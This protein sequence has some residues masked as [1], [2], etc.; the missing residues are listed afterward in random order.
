MATATDTRNNVQ[1]AADEATRATFRAADEASRATRE[2]AGQASRASLRAFDALSEYYLATFDAGLKFQARA[3]ESG[4]AILDETA[5]FQRS[6]RKLAEELL[7]TAR[8]TQEGLSDAAEMNLSAAQ[9]A[10]M[11]SHKR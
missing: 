2:I 4:K 1:S 10:W 7:Q 9:A 5:S 8:K 3:I 6:N 11:P